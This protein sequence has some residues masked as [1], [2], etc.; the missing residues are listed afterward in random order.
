M[1]KEIKWQNYYINA[2]KERVEY[3][4]K[5]KETDSILPDYIDADSRIPINKP[6]YE[7]YVNDILLVSD[8]KREWKLNTN[9]DRKYKICFQNYLFTTDYIGPSRKWA[10]KHK[11]QYKRLKFENELLCNSRILAG[12]IIWPTYNNKHTTN[13][14]RGGNGF[15]DRIDITL[16]LLQL[17]MDN[18]LYLK[19]EF[20]K[21][22][23]EKIISDDLKVTDVSDKVHE[24]LKSFH[25]YKEFYEEINS[26]REFCEINMLIGSFVT[27]SNESLIINNL[28]P[29]NNF[30]PVAKPN[31]T[32]TENNIKCIQERQKI[33]YNIVKKE[34]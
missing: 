23:L 33:I 9:K 13:R 28:Q 15:Y 10:N 34:T 24:V 8:S 32:Y 29:E 5:L 27:E 25:R 18:K 4:E 20:P 31:D 12:H 2:N 14:A 17:Y 11:E 3:V 6:L 16:K 19:E 7:D 22:I 30:L 21:S 1:S 26:F